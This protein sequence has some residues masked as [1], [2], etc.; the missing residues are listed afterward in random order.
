MLRSATAFFFLVLTLG[1]PAFGANKLDPNADIRQQVQAELQDFSHPGW[2]LRGADN[3][4]DAATSGQLTFS[5]AV[6]PALTEYRRHLDSIAGGTWP[7]VWHQAGTILWT[8][9]AGETEKLGVNVFFPR[10]P[11]KGTLL[12]VHGYL[13]H[14][15]NFAYTFAYF[16]ARGWTVVTMDLPGHGLSE[17]KRGDI[18]VF[19]EYGDA[20]ATWMNWVWKQNWHGPKWLMAHSLGAAS[21]FEALERPTTPQPDKVVFISPLLRPVWY[22]LAT[23]GDAIAGWAFP[24]F[25]SI[26]TWDQY[27]D[28]YAM[29][30]HWFQALEAWLARLDQRRPMAFPLTIY[31]GTGDQVADTSWNLAEYHRLVP[32]AK[33]VELP[34]ANHVFVSGKKERE[35][36]HSRLAADLGL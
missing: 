5:P 31:A 24:Y 21:C 30:R 33:I 36:F 34:E 14:A 28:G 4:G 16:T 3:Y 26:F 10:G 32:T 9:R 19:A 7:A 17:G 11:S 15:A 18:G 25:T 20:V 13:S 35:R 27:L 29:P 2:D 22:T 1:H 12:F 23:V 8:T 6:G